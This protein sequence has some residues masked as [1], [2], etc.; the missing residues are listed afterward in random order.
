MS[1]WLHKFATKYKVYA[2]DDDDSSDSDSDTDSDEKD[3]VAMHRLICIFFNR[4]MASMYGCIP[5]KFKVFCYE[6][7]IKISRLSKIFLEKVYFSIFRVL[8]A[9][10]ASILVAYEV[11]LNMAP[12]TFLS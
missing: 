11:F 6:S 7:M 8:L 10:G 3:D 12:H 5:D 4:T 9:T 1:I 2:R